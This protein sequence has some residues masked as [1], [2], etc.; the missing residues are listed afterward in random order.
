M[1]QDRIYLEC[2][3]C[4]K[5][6]ALFRVASA[7]PLEERF[8]SSNENLVSQL[9]AFVKEHAVGCRNLTITFEGDPGFIL[10]TES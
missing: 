9:D 5:E 8:T 6:Q 7:G 4:G 10:T 3:V 2:K 1:A